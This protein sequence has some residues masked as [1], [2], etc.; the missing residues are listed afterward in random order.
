MLNPWTHSLRMLLPIA[1][2]LLATS[3]Y[4]DARPGSALTASRQRQ[5]DDQVDQQTPPP[6]RPAPCSQQQDCTNK[7]PPGSKGC[8]CAPAPD[9]HKVCVPSCS[10]D[11]DCPSIPGVQLKCHDAV[12]APHPPAPR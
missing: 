2:A 3:A 12:C 7:C 10:V 8:T 11:S 6:P 4:A 5:A 1:I 9:G